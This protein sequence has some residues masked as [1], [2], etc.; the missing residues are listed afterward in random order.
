MTVQNLLYFLYIPKYIVVTM[1]EI[2]FEKFRFWLKIFVVKYNKYFMS[3]S[4]NYLA[5]TGSRQ[6]AYCQIPL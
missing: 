6:P 3:L 5:M 2:E 4:L 1:K